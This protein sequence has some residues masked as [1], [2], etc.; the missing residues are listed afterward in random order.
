MRKAFEHT[1]QKKGMNHTGMIHA[2][3]KQ[4]SLWIQ[5]C[6]ELISNNTDKQLLKHLSFHF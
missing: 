3:S 4:L 6:P 5:Y 1:A 2:K